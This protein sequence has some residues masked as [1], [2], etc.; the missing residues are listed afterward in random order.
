[1]GTACS[2]PFDPD[3]LYLEVTSAAPYAGLARK[4]FDDVVAFVATGGYALGA[5]ER[6]RRLKRLE[7]GRFA[8]AHPSLVRAYRMNVGT[9]VEAVTLKV[10]LKRGRVLGEGEEY[11]IQG[12]TPGETFMFAG[13]LLESAARRV[14]ERGVRTG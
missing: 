3:A 10:R 13:D 11:F 1:M 8:V 6:F 12:L 9:I 5:Y 2:G 14:G 7:D 4:D